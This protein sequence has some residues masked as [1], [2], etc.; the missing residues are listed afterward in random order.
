M[1][2][3]PPDLAKR[4]ECVQLA[5]PFANPEFLAILGPFESGSK[6]H[7]LHTLRDIRTRLTHTLRGE[8]KS[9]PVPWSYDVRWRSEPAHVGCYRG[10]KIYRFFSD[11][12]EF[13]VHSN[14]FFWVRLGST[15]FESRMEE[16]AVGETLMRL[17]D[18][19]T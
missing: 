2:L 19:A 14:Y 12:T 8:G 16:T 10:G 17:T 1:C 7:A 11:L 15:G 6:L 4:M 3:A 9:Q 18:L 5:T 13:L